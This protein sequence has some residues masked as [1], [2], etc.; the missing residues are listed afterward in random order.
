M[1]FTPTAFTAGNVKIQVIERK[2]V[3]NREPWVALQFPI[4][5]DVSALNPLRSSVEVF[6]YANPP[7]T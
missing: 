3:I 4:G 7:S 5:D 6:L 1:V 2:H